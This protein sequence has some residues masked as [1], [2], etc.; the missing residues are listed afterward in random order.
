MTKLYSI[1]AVLTLAGAAQADFFFI[2]TEGF[3]MG[4]GDPVIGGLETVVGTQ[5]GPY[6]FVGV[7]GDFSAELGLPEIPGEFEG[8]FFLFGPDMDTDVLTIMAS[9]LAHNGGGPDFFSYAGLWEVT[10]ATGIYDGLTGSGDFSGSH[11]FVEPE[12]G[13]VSLQIQGVLVPAPGI[14]LVLGLGGIVAARR[15]R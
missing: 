10:D 11:F 7:E 13:F 8:T 1:A 15:R 14:G 3:F 9:G 2:G 6:G 5:F 12:E 4:A